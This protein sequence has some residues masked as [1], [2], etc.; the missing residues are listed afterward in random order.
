MPLLL[1]SW[2]VQG[3]AHSHQGSGPGRA[4]RAR[5][6]RAELC[7]AR[8][9]AAGQQLQRARGGGNSCQATAAGAWGRHSIDGPCA[10]SCQ[11]AYAMHYLGGAYAACLRAV[12]EPQHSFAEA[13]VQLPS[14]LCPLW[15]A[16]VVGCAVFALLGLA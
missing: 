11:P 5:Q 3:L 10:C 16:Y 13:C 2:H 14:E 9:A 8:Y 12:M 4:G 6:A 1:C 15:V 7:F